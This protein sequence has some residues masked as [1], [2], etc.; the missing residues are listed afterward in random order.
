MQENSLAAAGQRLRHMKVVAVYVNA[1]VRLQLKEKGMNPCRQT[2]FLFHIGDFDILVCFKWT[3]AFCSIQRPY[4]MPSLLYIF[5][6]VT[7]E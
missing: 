2:M 7:C 4:F 3:A 1:F 6:C 5:V